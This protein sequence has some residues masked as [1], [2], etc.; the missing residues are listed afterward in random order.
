MVMSIRYLDT[1]ARN[2]GRWPFAA[3]QL[4]TDWTDKRP[5]TDH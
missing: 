5:S 3:R 1:F 4:V 2:D